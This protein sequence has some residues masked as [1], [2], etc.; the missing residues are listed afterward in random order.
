M[1]VILCIRKKKQKKRT[2]KVNRAE[3]DEYIKKVCAATPIVWWKSV[4]YHY[5][6]RTRQITRLANVFSCNFLFLD[7][8]DNK[9]TEL[10]GICALI[11]SCFLAWLFTYSVV[12]SHRLHFYAY[13]CLNFSKKLSDF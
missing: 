4:C 7:L 6:R 2:F 3:A 11:C 5:V 13:G 10:G 12:P 1:R 8:I 9:L